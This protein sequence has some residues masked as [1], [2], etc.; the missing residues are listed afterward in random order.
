MGQVRNLSNGRVELIAEG[1][2]PDLDEF[3]HAIRAE[4]GDKIHDVSISKIAG[5][6]PPRSGFFI[7][8]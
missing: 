4:L 5:D 2:P 6:E 1:S 3:L 7:V 8:Y